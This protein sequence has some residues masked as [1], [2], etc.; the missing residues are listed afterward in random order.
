MPGQM[1][2]TYTRRIGAGKPKNLPN[3]VA[4]LTIQVSD[5]YGVHTFNHTK[6]VA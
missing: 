3:A 4:W 5:W 2:V 1:S 6:V